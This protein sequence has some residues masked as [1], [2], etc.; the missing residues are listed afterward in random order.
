MLKASCAWTD[1]SDGKRCIPG[2]PLGGSFLDSGCTQ[3]VV[4]VSTS[5][6]QPAPVSLGYIT[7]SLRT[8]CSSQVVS[9]NSIGDPISGTQYFT[10]GLGGCNPVTISTGTTL[11]AV[12][13]AIPL[14]T[15]VKAVPA[16]ETGTGRL[17]HTYLV[18]EDGAR[19]VTGIQ[20]TQLGVPCQLQGSR[21]RVRCLPDFAS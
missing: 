2:S 8:T 21:D 5:S 11:H 12:G 16:I 7:I 1:T 14:S 15:F 4:L 3:P 18:A 13:A 20:D 6:C 10:S 17:A 19:I 9:V